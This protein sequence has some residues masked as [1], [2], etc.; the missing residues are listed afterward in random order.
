[1]VTLLDQ[2]NVARDIEGYRD[3]PPGLRIWGGATVESDDIQKLTP[4][5][6]WAWDTIRSSE[7]E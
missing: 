1:M 4:W 2:E 5:L 7:H 3:A 6:N